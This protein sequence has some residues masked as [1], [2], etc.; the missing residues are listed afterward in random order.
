M[1]FTG[2]SAFADDDGGR[3]RNAKYDGPITEAEAARLFGALESVPALILAVSGGPDSTAMMWLAA[4]WRDELEKSPKLIAV[5]IDHGL[6]KESAREAR[7][8]ARLAKTLNV[9]HVTLR[10]TGRKPK[11]GIQEAARNARYRLLSE[12]AHRQNAMHILTAHTLDDQ[13]ETLLF[14]M[15][16][17][18][19]VSGLVGMRWF[20]GIPVS[21]AK[22]ANL[23]RP[24]LEVPKAR[25]IATL[26]AAKV[27][28]AVDPSNSDARFTRPRLRKLM[29]S[30][31]QEGL[32]AERLGKLAKRVERAEE[33]LFVALNA[34]QLALCP[35]PW[36]DGDPLS[37]DA[38]A[39]VDLP[40]EIGLRLLS[41]MIVHVGQQGGAELGQLEALYSELQA[42]GPHI[43]T[44]REFGPV[45]RNVAGALVTLS[46]AFLTVEREP[47][48]RI[49][50]KPRK[51]QRKARF[52]TAG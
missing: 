3:L 41:R 14:R 52:T 26:K 8:V 31:A 27:P 29:L 16:R 10:W 17:G 23:V 6:R 48:R 11:T 5:T 21:G 35:G 7:A 45:R 40:E 1:M 46:S 20:D 33:A 9:E 32:T 22:P 25:L 50:R 49:V 37:A 2:S 34:A 4:R 18:T 38:E 47:P 43:R 44:D 51:S 30:L 36:P 28:Y 13:A 19:G 24:F 12:E 42:M 39:F 15:A